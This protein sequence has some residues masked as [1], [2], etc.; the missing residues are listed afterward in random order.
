MS[1]PWHKD[2]FSERDRA[3]PPLF[4]DK[5][6]G[7]PLEARVLVCATGPLGEFVAAQEQMLKELSIV[8]ELKVVEPQGFG[9]L[10]PLQSE[11]VEGLL[12]GVQAA[13]GEKCERCWIRSDHPTICSRCFTV[14]DSLNP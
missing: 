7:H 1:F 2:L 4:I 9:D 3:S 13:P 14:V 10:E 6:I 12:I 5:T 11:E 8:S